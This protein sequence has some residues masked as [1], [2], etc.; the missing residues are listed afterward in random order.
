MAL[1]SRLKYQL[2]RE[3]KARLIANGLGNPAAMYVRFN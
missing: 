1:E 3:Q 2:K